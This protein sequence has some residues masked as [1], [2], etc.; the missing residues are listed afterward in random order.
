MRGATDANVHYHQ[1]PNFN[2]FHNNTKYQILEKMKSQVFV[3][4][5]GYVG[6]E[7]VDLLLSEGQY[8][9]TTLVR[10][11]AAVEE[12]EKDGAG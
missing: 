6:R 9:I 10:R 8:E 11:E 3:L 7:I 2:Q 12:F 4:G 1:E 5:P